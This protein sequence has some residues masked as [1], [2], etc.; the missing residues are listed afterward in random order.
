MSNQE[1][2][3]FFMGFAAVLILVGI[4]LYI[5]MDICLQTIAK[6][7]PLLMDGWNGYQLPMYF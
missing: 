2:I 3:T 4:I 1:L 7:L 6:K 5:Y